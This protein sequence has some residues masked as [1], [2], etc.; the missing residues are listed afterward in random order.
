LGDRPQ[1]GAPAP[2]R[3]PDLRDDLRPPDHADPALRLRDQPG[4]AHLRA[5]A[6]DLA[7]SARSRALVADAEASQALDVVARARDAGRLE[8]LLRRGEVSVGLL[9]PRDF[10][11]R[12]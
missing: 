12:V 6:V 5:A 4:R 7:G 3:P 9:V 2:P 10:E 1:G 8:A 11:R